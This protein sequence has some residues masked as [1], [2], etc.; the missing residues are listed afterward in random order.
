MGI[1][2]NAKLLIAAYKAGL[3]NSYFC[4][5]W[6]D[7]STNHNKPIIRRVIVENKRGDSTIQYDTDANCHLVASA[8]TNDA[9]WT[10]F[11]VACYQPGRRYGQV[12]ICDYEV[13]GEHHFYSPLYFIGQVSVE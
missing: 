11:Y 13:D 4:C 7:A 1:I 10:L 5:G 8:G 6:S 3:I 12:Y 9:G 2:D